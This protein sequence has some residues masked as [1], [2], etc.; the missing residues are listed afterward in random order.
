MQQ[1]ALNRIH[2]LEDGA[3]VTDQVI[4]KRILPVNR[5]KGD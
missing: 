1:Q 5:I 2:Y 3:L 4:Q